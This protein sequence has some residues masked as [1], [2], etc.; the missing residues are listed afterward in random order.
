MRLTAPSGVKSLQVEEGEG[1]QLV[2]VWVSGVCAPSRRRR[3]PVYEIFIE[4]TEG[5]RPCSPK[6]FS[7][8]GRHAVSPGRLC[9]LRMGSAARPASCFSCNVIRSLGSSGPSSGSFFCSVEL[10]IL[11]SVFSFSFCCVWA[12]F[13][14]RRCPSRQPTPFHF[15]RS[16]AFCTS[17]DSLLLLWCK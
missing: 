17:S 10:E 16:P 7:Q 12:G 8:T 3:F 1:G 15:P 6:S 14:R 5:G 4:H 9:E 13:S 2:F 11:F